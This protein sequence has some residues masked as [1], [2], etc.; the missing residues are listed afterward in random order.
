MDE[1][2]NDRIR[3]FIIKNIVGKIGYS[4]DT[5][6]FQLSLRQLRSDDR[7]TFRDEM[8][9]YDSWNNMT[10]TNI[11]RFIDDVRLSVGLCDKTRKTTFPSLMLDQIAVGNIVSLLEVDERRGESNIR[12]LYVGKGKTGTFRFFVLSSNRT[13][14]Q[15][16]DI[17]EPYGCN[18][19][20]IDH[21]V[22]FR[23]FRD[24][25]R[26]PQGKDRLYLTYPLRHI[27][28]ETPSIV[29][30]VIDSRNDFTYE[31]YMARKPSGDSLKLTFTLPSMAVLMHEYSSMMDFYGDFTDNG[32]NCQFTS[33]PK[34]KD[35]MSGNL[36]MDNE[37]M[38]L[39]L[40]SKSKS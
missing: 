17:V 21:S 13:A 32:T 1:T 9:K 18:V 12:L 2:I 33:N 26:I 3:K 34:A 5:R 10:D 6:S 20:S 31:E 22:A 4:S 25:V 39:R 7:Q 8:R 19:W 27:S 11:G 37:T 16:E 15:P 35:K 36:R 40:V 24:G 14:L 23:V 28:L 29:H 38:E 30:E